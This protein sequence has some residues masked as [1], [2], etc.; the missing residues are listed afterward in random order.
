M[1]MTNVQKYKQLLLNVKSDDKLI[2]LH[3][4]TIKS[5]GIMQVALVDNDISPMD[6]VVLCFLVV[7]IKD[8]IKNCNFEVDA[9]VSTFI[10][11]ID[12]LL[13]LCKHD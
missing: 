11:E 7:F 10:E 4:F 6:V 9:S 5:D 3:D 2:T 12:D 13:K 8:G 1:K